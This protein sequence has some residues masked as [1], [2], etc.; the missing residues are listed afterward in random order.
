MRGQR[1]QFCISMVLLITVLS[2]TAFAVFW[3]VT[4]NAAA[5]LLSGCIVV[6]GRLR[7]SR[8]FG[9]FHSLVRLYSSRPSCQLIGG[10]PGDPAVDSVS[11]VT[12]LPRRPGPRC[13]ED[14][15]RCRTG[16]GQSAPYAM[17]ATC[18]GR[19]GPLGDVPAASPPRV[20]AARNIQTTLPYYVGA[21]AERTG[22]VSRRNGNNSGNTARVDGENAPEVP[23]TVSE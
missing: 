1:T 22:D 20:E 10:S 6:A 13:G 9:Q 4:E 17:P 15:L 19:L 18:G 21:A 8:W 14:G 7:E 23:Q 5:E 16:Q 2:C 11:R 12:R 3:P